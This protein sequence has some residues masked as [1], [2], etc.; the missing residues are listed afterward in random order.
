MCSEKDITKKS[1]VLSK[2]IYTLR[3]LSKNVM[4]ICSDVNSI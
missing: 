2:Y 4:E 1:S 3:V